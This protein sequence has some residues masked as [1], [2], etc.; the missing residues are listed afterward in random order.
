MLENQWISGEDQLISLREN[1]EG[2][3]PH[4]QLHL[5]E[6]GELINRK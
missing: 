6:I 4:L 1:I 2:Y 3:L 5:A